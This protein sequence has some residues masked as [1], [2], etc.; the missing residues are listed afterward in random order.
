[1]VALFHDPLMLLPSQNPLQPKDWGFFIRAHISHLRGKS[2]KKGNQQNSCEFYVPSA[3]FPVCFLL[4]SNI[5]IRYEG[6]GLVG[7]IEANKHGNG[8]FLVPDLIEVV[9]FFVS[10]PNTQG[11]NL[12][13]ISRLHLIGV[14]L[15]QNRLETRKLQATVEE[16]VRRASAATFSEI[17][18]FSEF[19]RRRI[20]QNI[21][22]L[23]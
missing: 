20:N 11:F 10:S 6:D 21:W 15:L 4:S 1:M 7:L 9:F 23:I 5:K 22:L 13:M 17:P 18:F 8:L 14:F 12:S 2:Q 16:P 3:D 19:K